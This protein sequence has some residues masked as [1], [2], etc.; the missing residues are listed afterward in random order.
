M[1]TVEDNR[2]VWNAE[3]AWPAGGDEWSRPWGGSDMEWHATLL[4]RIRSFLPCDTILEIAP[5]HGRWSIYLR[6]L[7]RRLILVDLSETA[8]A[9]C[10]RR[11]A[12]DER[13]VC[14]VNDGSSLAMI[15]DGTI[16]F[17]FSF[18][19]LVHVE[20]ETLGAYVEQLA[21]KLAPGGAAFLHHSNLGEYRRYYAAAGLLPS[22]VRRG[23][24]RLR[25]LDRDHWRARSVTAGTVRARA[26]RAGLCCPSQELV[27]W[28]TRRLIDGMTVLARPESR[29]ARPTAVLRNRRFMQEAR[30][31][32]RLAALY[33]GR[34]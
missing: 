32:A 7:C 10:R 21:R 29:W 9:A 18:D 30:G 25:L 6:D 20:M 34:T 27:N 2:R 17:A 22:I 11:F 16:D 13:V 26:E 4:P 15:P 19:S 33:G 31:A 5:G 8:I 24:A 3:Y 28:G 14:H 1:P 12:G 23:L